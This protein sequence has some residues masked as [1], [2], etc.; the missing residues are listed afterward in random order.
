MDEFATKLF[1]TISLGNS[2]VKFQ[3]D[4]GATCN[5]LPEHSTNELTPTRKWL[6]KYNNR[7]IKPL[8]TC[9][10]EVRSPK[11]FRS[12]HVEFVVVDSDRA[13]LI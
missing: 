10:M 4:S 11:N 6:A 3:L 5:L 1:A 9:T 13:V 8:D 7:M 2:V 12:Y